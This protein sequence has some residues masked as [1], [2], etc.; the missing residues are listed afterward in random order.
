M[1]I[2]LSDLTF[3]CHHGLYEEETIVGGNYVVD[4]EIKINTPEQTIDSIE[5]TVNYVAAY[6]LVKKRMM[7]PTPLLETI[8]MELCDQLLQLSLL[9]QSVTI[10]IRKF[11]LPIAGFQG[12]TAVKFAKEK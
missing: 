12:H 6:D 7:Q 5:E 11:A 1:T 10:S 4:V 8:V 9:V 3:Y 2:Y